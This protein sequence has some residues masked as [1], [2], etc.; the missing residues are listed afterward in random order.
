M[1]ILLKNSIESIQSYRTDTSGFIDII[2]SKHYSSIETNNQLGLL[3]FADGIELANSSYKNCWPVFITI[4]DLPFSLRNSSSHF[5]ICGSWYGKSK[6]SSFQL[7]SCLREEVKNTRN[8]PISIISSRTGDE[9][10]I[11]LEF[12]GF[13]GDTPAKAMLLN[14]KSHNGYYSCPYCLIE[15]YF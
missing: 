15:G 8:S 9:F 14:M 7:F 1:R 3:V 12:Y 5:V 10:R 11:T 4:C 13:I 6:P 2:N